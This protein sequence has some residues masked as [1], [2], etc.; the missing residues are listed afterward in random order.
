MSRVREESSIHGL[1]KGLPIALSH[2]GGVITSAGL[3]LASTFLVL[4]S[5]PVRE[6]YQLGITVAIGILLDTFVVRGFLVP[7]IVLLLRG[8]NWWPGKLPQPKEAN[9]QHD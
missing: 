1:A 5:M 7:G 6:L 3:I 8:A 9:E 4:S 2:T